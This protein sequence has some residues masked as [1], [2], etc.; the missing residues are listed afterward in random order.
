[1]F[2]LDSKNKNES[3]FLENL[4]ED[5]I[6]YLEYIMRKLDNRND[7]RYEEKVIN[8]SI[9]RS[10]TTYCSMKGFI[11]DTDNL[12]ELIRKDDLTLKEINITH[13]QI[14]DVLTYFTEQSNLEK[15]IN[16][17]NFNYKLLVSFTMGSQYCPFTL[18]KDNIYLSNPQNITCG[19]GNSTIHIER[20]D[21]KRLSYSNMMP[22]LIEHHHFFEGNVSYRLD[23]R[24]VVDFFNL[25]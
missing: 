16:F 1:M 23:P 9:K 25:R 20:D 7:S 13:K 8:T 12:S 22:H 2:D 17:N 5:K 10:I 3:L 19:S 4:S 24:Y 6:R 11:S 18:V 21:K 15:E 14:A